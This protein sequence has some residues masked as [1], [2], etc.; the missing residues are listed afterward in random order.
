MDII[1]KA[2]NCDVPDRVKD[3]AVER[4]E[5]ATRLFD[6]LN[7][8][9]MVFSEEANPRIPE[10]AIV[11]V[12]ARTKGTHIRAQG[13]G[14]DHRQATDAAVARFERQLRRYKSRLVDRTQRAAARGTGVAE[15]PA[16]L[17]PK[18]AEEADVEDPAPRIVRHKT[19]DIAELLPEDAALQL[20]LL[21]HDFFL[22]TNAATGRCNVVYRRRDGD[23]G[24]IEP[25]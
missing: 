21:G 9:E 7:G 22:F 12:T 23:L 20:E 3:R 11:E 14:P 8:I 15:P 5:H 6:R 24:L 18:P 2:K 4:V 1:V 13:V 17:A 16:E 25:S 10:P 19:F